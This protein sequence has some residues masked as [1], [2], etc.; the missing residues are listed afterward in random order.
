M[1]PTPDFDPYPD[2]ETAVY[3]YTGTS[4]RLPDGEDGRRIV[5][6]GDTV[7]LPDHVAEALTDALEELAADGLAE[8]VE[9]AAEFDSEMADAE[10]LEDAEIEVC[11]VVKNDG[12]VCGRELP[13]PYHD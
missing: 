10:D 3:R 5:T 11:D 9:A 4:L 6:D 8:S 13:C 12:E 7:A 1:A 2:A